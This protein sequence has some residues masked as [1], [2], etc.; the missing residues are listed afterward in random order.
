MVLVDSSGR[1]SGTA[2]KNEVHGLDCPLHLGFS[3][4]VFNRA[5]LF[6]A[7]RRAWTKVTWP[8]W[9]T[10][11][12]CGHPG[13]GESGEDAVRRR[14]AYELGMSAAQVVEALPD[15]SYSATWGGASENE[16]CPVYLAVTDDEPS[17]N[18]D[19]VAEYR[20]LPFSSFVAAADRITPWA[21]QQL[22]LLYE[23]VVRFRSE[24]GLPD[25]AATQGDVLPE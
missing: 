19:E 1:P 20:W 3:S 25:P 5:G 23:Q 2:P 24:C 9:W 17:P 6:L 14:L 13:L 10:N 12:C 7:T 4:Y 18:P 8:G 21:Q 22:P 16:L 11:S 15:F